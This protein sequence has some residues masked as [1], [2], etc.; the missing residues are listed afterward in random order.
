MSTAPV[1]ACPRCDATL[2]NGQE[3]CLACGLRVPG[4][5]RF[6]ILP[7]EPR[8]LL[9][10]L[11]ALGAV[12]LA[13]AVLAVWLTSEP[14][15]AVTVVTATGGSVAVAAPEGGSEPSPAAWPPATD[16]W[17]VI[18]LS[19][20]KV[21]GRAVAVQAA[22]DARSKG[23]QGVGIIDSSRFPSLQP[24]YWMVFAGRFTS[25]PEATSRLQRARTVS[26]SA[27]VQRIAS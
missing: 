26:K 19:V 18:L 1:P 7:V 13:G 6:G 23:L 20:P 10:P 24:G 4:S 11:V 5:G 17:T 25:E 9:A 8:H 16:G 21:R 27:R 3:Y 15:Q 22:R 12:A 2:A 14:S